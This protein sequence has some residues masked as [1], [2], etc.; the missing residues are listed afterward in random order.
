MEGWGGTPCSQGPSRWGQILRPDRRKSLACGDG[1]DRCLGEV[2]WQRGVGGRERT[3]RIQ[4]KRIQGKRITASSASLC[5]EARER[6]ER[7]VGSKHSLLM[8]K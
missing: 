4:I 5:D 7:W 3:R 8:L 1:G 2:V 6:W